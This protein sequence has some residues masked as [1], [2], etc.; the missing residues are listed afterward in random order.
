MVN[1]GAHVT[2][3][4]PAGFSSPPAD[5][6]TYTACDPGGLCDTAAVAV[7]VQAVNHAPAPADDAATTQAG[8]AVTIP[9][10]ANDSDPDGDVLTLD[11]AGAPAHG[12]AAANAD[13]TVTYTPAPGFVGEDELTYTV[14]DGELTA[15]A[16]VRVTVEEESNTGGEPTRASGSGSI[17]LGG[18]SASFAV[19]AHAGVTAPQGRIRYTAGSAGPRLQGVVLT[20]SFPSST[21][22]ELTGSCELGDGSVCTY[23]AAVEDH[24]EPGKDRDRF[25][26][27]VFDAA[28]NLVHQADGA[29]TAGHI[30]IR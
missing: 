6:F 23:Q 9:V 11:G 30:R 20:T 4:P 29:L 10:L 21:R 12:T 27:R 7:T 22:A 24:G 28:G 26:I 18:G 14:S 5:T 19:N 1:R 15:T 16:R 3:T 13:G 8:S 2:Y 25:A 17:P